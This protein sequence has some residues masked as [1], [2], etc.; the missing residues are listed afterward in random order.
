MKGRII[1]FAI[2]VTVLALDAGHAQFGEAF[3][4]WFRLEEADHAAITAAEDRILA[5]EPLGPGTTESWA[6]D[7]T[8]NTGTISILNVF[9]KDGMPCLETAYDFKIARTA[10][11]IRYVVP[12]CQTA[13]GS[14]KMAF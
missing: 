14:W 8:G 12:W 4:V 5:A 13:D 9:E 1:G 11:P 3:P 6:G 2:A 10:D 7:V